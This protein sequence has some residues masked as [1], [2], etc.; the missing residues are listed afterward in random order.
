MM[1][2]MLAN[3]NMEY[4]LHFPTRVT[5]NSETAM[6]NSLAQT[7]FLEIISVEGII[8]CLS[9]YD[10]RMIKINWKN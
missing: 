8:T 2:I 4:L 9:N 3:Y 6:D 7:L 5:N 10:G 1:S